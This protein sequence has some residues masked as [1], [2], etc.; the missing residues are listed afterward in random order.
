MTRGLG[1]A[2]EGLLANFRMDPG[3]KWLGKAQEMGD[4]LSRA[5]H[6]DGY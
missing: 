6:E 4:H 2:M 5:Q 3:T 1:W